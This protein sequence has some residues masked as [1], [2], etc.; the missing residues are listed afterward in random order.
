[1]VI[2]LR[3]ILVVLLILPAAGCKKMM[4]VPDDCGS[5][6]YNDCNTTEPDVTEAKLTFSITSRTP[7]VPFII[8]K[9]NVESGKPVFYDTAFNTDVYYYLEFGKYSVKAEYKTDDKT[10]YVIDGDEAEKWSNNI[11]DSVCWGW[12][13]LGFDLRIH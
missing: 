12:D 10:I 11:C 13:S 1:M 6:N 5:Y 8:Y 2:K 4:P 7:Y 9:G 3:I